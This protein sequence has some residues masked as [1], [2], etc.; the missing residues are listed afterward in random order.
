ML[1]SF[2][3]ARTCDY[4]RAI[5]MISMTRLRRLFILTWTLQLAAVAAVAHHAYTAEFDATRPIKL[6][7]VL[8]KVEWSNPHI[9]LYLDVKDDK[10][11]VTNWGFSASPPG[12][13]QRRG[14]TKNTLKVGEVLTISGHR[15]KDGSN[16]AS[17]NVVTFADGRDALIGQDQALNP[18]EARP[19][20]G[21]KQ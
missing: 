14:I 18:T 19:G 17:G 7:G 9:W 12:M 1:V 15:A 6:S 4:N 8:T 11:N 13:L 20:A 2:V 10:G 5:K 3:A 21:K 16:N